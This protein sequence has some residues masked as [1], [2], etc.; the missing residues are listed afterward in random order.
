MGI[1][2]WRTILR[3]IDLAKQHGRKSVRTALRVEATFGSRDTL[4]SIY[5]M[6]GRGRKESRMGRD[7][8]DDFGVWSAGIGKTK[9]ALRDAPSGC[10]S[11]RMAFICCVGMHH[12]FQER[13]IG[14]SWFWLGFTIPFFFAQ[15][16]EKAYIARHK[17]GV[18]QGRFGM[19]HGWGLG[20]RF[21]V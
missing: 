13:I 4:H 14:C 11:V 16:G 7:S 17:Q 21:S 15:G 20:L 10:G 12:G 19:G 3:F 9:F 2:R 6:D 18:L 8:E 1:R 5:D